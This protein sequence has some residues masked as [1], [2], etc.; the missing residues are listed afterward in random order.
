MWHVWGAGEVHTEFWWGNLMER[1]HLE[2]L[3]VDWIMLNGFLKS[4][5]ER[6]GL[7]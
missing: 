2:D 5:I 3:D 4:E 6:Q 7:D 1:Y